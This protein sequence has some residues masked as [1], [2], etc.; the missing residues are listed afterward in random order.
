MRELDSAHVSDFGAFLQAME[1]QS[2]L[3]LGH[4]DADCDAL[5]SAY[6]M[7]CLLPGDVGF[8]QGL[9]TSAQDLARWLDF[10]PLI[11]PDPGAYDFTIIYDTH[12]PSLLGLAVPERYALFDHH[13]PGGH[14]YSDFQNELRAEAAWSWVLPLESTCS[15]LAEL[16]AANNLLLDRRM[17]IALAA[18]LVTD[19]A[20]LDL[21]N[22]AALRR[23]ATILEGADLY[24]E[25]VFM[26][27][28]SPLRRVSRRSAVLKSLRD[29]QETTIG[30]WSTLSAVTDSHDHGFAVA[31]AFRRLGADVCAVA[32]PKEGRSMAMVECYSALSE[33]MG[34]DL[35]QLAGDLADLLDASESW[36]TRCFGRIIA[37][38][39]PDE[40][41]DLCV[42]A[43][44]EALRNSARERGHAT[45]RRSDEAF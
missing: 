1:G 25:D 44:G 45:G 35:R 36:G 26:A 2:L 4:K 39:P 22:G 23:L 5:A 18:G 17:R 43:V 31:S 10:C 8:A 38:M 37:Q 15:I 27:I 28:D 33:T 19:T 12:S 32:F 34:I 40:L 29:A 41:L 20:W 24:L 7:S 42:T 6:A 30:P 9:K 3:H 21:A 16:L 13:V 14:R 11:D